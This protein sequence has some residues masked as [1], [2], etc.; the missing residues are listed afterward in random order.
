M[1]DSSDRPR[2]WPPSPYQLADRD[3]VPLV[4][5]GGVAAALRSTAVCLLDDPRAAR[6]VELGSQMLS[7]EIEA[8]VRHGRDPPHPASGGRSAHSSLRSARDRARRSRSRRSRRRSSRAA[9]LTDDPD[10]ASPAAIGLLT[11]E[12]E[13]VSV[14]LEPSAPAR[15]A[16]EAASRARSRLPAAPPVGAP[17]EASVPRSPRRRLSVPVL[18]LIVGVTLVGIAAVFFLVF[19]WFVWGIT[20]RAL[21]IG[22]I[23]LAAIV[24]RLA[25]ATAEPDGDS[26][27]HRGPRDRAAR[28]R[29]V[30]RPRERLLRHRRQR[31][32][33]LRGSVGTRRRGGLPRVGAVRE[34]ARAG[35]RGRPRAAHGARTPHRRSARRCRRPKPPWR[36]SS[37]PPPAVCC[38]LFPL[39][40][41]RP[42]SGRDAVPERLVLAIIG[43]TALAA[44]AV[45][46]AFMTGYEVPVI[47]WSSILV[48][49]L[50]T[51][52]ALLLRP[53]PDEEPLPAATAL[54]GVAST[55]AVATLATAG[56]QL[57]FRAVEPVYGG[58]VAPVLAVAT[59]VAVDLIRAR[60]GGLKAGLRHRS[61]HRRAQHPGRARHRGLCV[62]PSAI[63]SSWTIWQTDAFAP[64]PSFLP[65]PYLALATAVAIAFLLLIAP[66]LV[67][68]RAP[69]PPDRRRSGDC[70][71]RPPRRPRCPSS[72]SASPWR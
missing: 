11:A 18:L 57:S 16:A 19:A 5:R 69:R 26:G 30:G 52:H 3:A 55:V 32:G 6:V 48:P 45:T 9:S 37:A 58:F 31:P 51:A 71:S 12:A 64:P 17:I 1:D 62:P 72:S 54:A 44:A 46:A 42:G 41:R 2:L 47:V 22:G 40:G 70:C 56:W 24:E 33:D 39:R 38:T 49:V 50:G 4:L 68:S 53:R 43:V 35:C 59:A 66:S 23:T 34:A 65:A 27:G 8:P 7:L 14:H 61:R 25:A 60:R 15:A 28:A 20:V 10:A 29:C 36:D 63:A 67:T 13:V 21:I